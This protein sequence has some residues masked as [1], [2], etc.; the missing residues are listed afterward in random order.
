MTQRTTSGALRL[1]NRPSPPRA[2]TN[3]NGAFVLDTGTHDLSANLAELVRFVVSRADTARTAAAAL[4]VTVTQ[5]GVLARQYAVE[6]PWRP[7][8]KGR[9]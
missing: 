2:Y 5:L 4:G 6:L 3:A 7:S 1:A 8:T 9:R